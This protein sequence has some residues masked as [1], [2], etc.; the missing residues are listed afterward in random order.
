MTGHG[1][2]MRMW[3]RVVVVSIIVPPTVHSTPTRCTRMVT[4]IT[5]RPTAA[6]VHVLRFHHVTGA[7]IRSHHGRRTAVMTWWKHFR[8]HFV[9]T[10]TTTT[11]RQ[12]TAV[13]LNATLRRLLVVVAHRRTDHWHK[14][15]R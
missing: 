10:T 3:I 4:T 1:I 9:S 8:V 12:F 7:A 11:V 15:S 5:L 14:C 13:T 2:V 6:R